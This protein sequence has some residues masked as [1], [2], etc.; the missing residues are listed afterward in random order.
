MKMKTPSLL[1]LPLLFSC[2]SVTIPDEHYYRLSVDDIQRGVARP[3]LGAIRVDSMQ[4]D[5]GLAP[6]RLLVAD[7]SR[8]R[9]LGYGFHRWA[10][11][12]V[13]PMRPARRVGPGPALR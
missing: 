8:V 7:A 1:L 3:E 13:G 11:P 5:A 4:L 2:G 6:D 10:G 12:L 9:L